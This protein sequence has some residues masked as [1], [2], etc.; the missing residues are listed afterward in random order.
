M[1]TQRAI[2]VRRRASA[3]AAMPTVV[4]TDCELRRTATGSDVTVRTSGLI[5]H[6]GPLRIT[7]GGVPVGDVRVAPSGVITGTVA[8]PPLTDEVV[9]D[10]GTP[11]PVSGRITSR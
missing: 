7:V 11:A 4:I 3:R 9:L 8:R 1:S 10:A 6:A 5:P 2:W